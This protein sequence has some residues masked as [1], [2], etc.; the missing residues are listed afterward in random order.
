MMVFS[1]AVMLILMVF[2]FIVKHFEASKE[3][4]KPHFL[5]DL[6]VKEGL[7]K[8]KTPP[9][10]ESKRKPVQTKTSKTKQQP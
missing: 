8:E 1:I 9:E 10:R 4:K 2:Y 3:D 7:K 5:D 6:E